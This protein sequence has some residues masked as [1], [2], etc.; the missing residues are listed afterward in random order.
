MDALLKWRQKS[1]KT[2]QKLYCLVLSRQQ[3]GR[4][5]QHWPS[6]QIDVWMIF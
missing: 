1:A 2:G 4:L 6:K 3:N 5:V